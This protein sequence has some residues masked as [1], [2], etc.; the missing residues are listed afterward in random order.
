M[1][2]VLYETRYDQHNYFWYYKPS[3]I[4]PFTLSEEWIALT[5]SGIYF[6]GYGESEWD[7]PTNE[8]ALKDLSF[9]SSMDKTGPLYGRYHR[10]P[11]HVN[12]VR[13]ANGFY[14]FFFNILFEKYC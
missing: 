12:Q 13:S 6:S 11:G 4:D 7:L 9:R 10:S 14:R 5:Y 2:V 1:F 3:I 8:V